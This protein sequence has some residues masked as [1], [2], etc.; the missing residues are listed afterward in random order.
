LV[1]ERSSPAYAL[2]SPYE[3]RWLRIL[4]SGRIITSFQALHRAVRKL[5]V[6]A[7]GQLGALPTNFM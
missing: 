2:G 1:L 4:K 6:G 3:V 7:A 5:I